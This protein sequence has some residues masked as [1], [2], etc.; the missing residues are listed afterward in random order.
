MLLPK[1]RQR[2]NAKLVVA[3][4]G[5]AVSSIPRERTFKPTFKLPLN[6]ANELNILAILVKYPECHWY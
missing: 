5:I 4:T 2:S 6:L 3:F 1:I